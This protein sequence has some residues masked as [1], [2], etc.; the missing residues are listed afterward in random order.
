MGPQL[1]TPINTKRPEMPYGQLLQLLAQQ[2]ENPTSLS[3]VWGF[4]LAHPEGLEPPAYGLEIRWH[5]IH[6]AR[7]DASPRWFR[8]GGLLSRLL[9]ENRRN[10]PEETS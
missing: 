1:S 6:R 2:Q 10:P 5:L 4:I 7:R 3:G 9:R 8:P